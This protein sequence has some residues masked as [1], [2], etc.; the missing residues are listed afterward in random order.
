MNPGPVIEFRGIFL[1][2]GVIYRLLVEFFEEDLEF[3]A[4]YGIPRSLR[5]YVSHQ[6]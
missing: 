4:F 6:I 3:P 2:N 5:D 1:R